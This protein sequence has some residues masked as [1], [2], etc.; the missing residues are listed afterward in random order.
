MFHFNTVTRTSYFEHEVVGEGLDHCFDCASEIF[1][2]DNFLK[3]V[4]HVE[5]AD[6]RA[7]A[8]AVL[9]KEISGVCS[10]KPR[11][12]AGYSSHV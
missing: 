11:S 6:K 4:R 10:R 1:I 9:S 7:E 3:E 2:L 12:L 8:V 5:D